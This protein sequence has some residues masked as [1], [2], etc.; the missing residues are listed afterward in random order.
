MH[1]NI[2]LGTNLKYKNMTQFDIIT[3]DYCLI[4]KYDYIPN[5][6]HHLITVDYD[7]SHKSRC[8]SF[9]RNKFNHQR[10]D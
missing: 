10:K 2:G 8:L 9:I 1:E 3:N 5:Y 4:M 6:I 7:L